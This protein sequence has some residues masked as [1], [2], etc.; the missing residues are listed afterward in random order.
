MPPTASISG[1]WTVG[2]QGYRA[3]LWKVAPAGE[4]VVCI[5]NL[6]LHKEVARASATIAE[7]ENFATHLCNQ[8]GLVDSGIFALGKP[9][10][11]GAFTPRMAWRFEP[12]SQTLR[13]LDVATVNCIYSD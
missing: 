3:E 6:D 9:G 7:G 2:T 1:S 13:L 10:E 4:F 12:E 8:E 11:A 5:I